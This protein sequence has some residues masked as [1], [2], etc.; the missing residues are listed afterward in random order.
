MK[1]NEIERNDLGFRHHKFVV[2]DYF[3]DFDLI[4]GI[5]NKCSR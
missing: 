4:A 2:A 3:L 5:S 1:F